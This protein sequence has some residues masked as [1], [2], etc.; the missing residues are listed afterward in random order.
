MTGIP[1][2]SET[3]GSLCLQLHAK[4]NEYQAQAVARAHAEA[5]YKAAKA[6]RVLK[7][8]AEGEKAISAAQ[9]VAEADDHIKDL[10]LKFLIAEG[11][12]DALTKGMIALRE[13][14][15]YGRSLM[16]TQREVD[17]LLATHGEG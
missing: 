7:A 8:R 14:I 9:T 5:E 17:K 11:M 6:K 2:A 12:T 16:A 15:N 10:H 3:V 4:A 13:R 1:Q